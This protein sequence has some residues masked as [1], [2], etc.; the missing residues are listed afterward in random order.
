M[1]PKAPPAIDMAAAFTDV[2][3]VPIPYPVLPLNQ[4]PQAQGAVPAPGAAFAALAGINSAPAASAR[5]A[6]FAA[7]EQ[8]GVFAGTDGALAEMAANPY[9]AYCD[10]PMLGCVLAA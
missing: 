9:Q 3:V 5:A 4:A 10:E 2:P 6:F 8:L 7:F 1:F